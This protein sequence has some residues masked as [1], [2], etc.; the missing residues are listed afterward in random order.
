[1]IEPNPKF[2]PP[3]CIFCNGYGYDPEQPDTLNLHPEDP[4]ACR[5]CLGNGVLLP[6]LEYNDYGKLLGYNYPEPQQVLY[7]ADPN[8]RHVIVEKYSG[9]QCAKCTGW[10][11]S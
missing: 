2:V 4:I 3:K 10:Y 11:C 7:N 6:E 1:M 5:Y 9:V 8:C